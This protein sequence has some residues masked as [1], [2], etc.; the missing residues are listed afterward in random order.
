MRPVYI[1]AQMEKANPLG[2]IRGLVL[3]LVVPMGWG[4]K[5]PLRVMI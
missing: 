5:K 3:V 1:R 2:T 4:P